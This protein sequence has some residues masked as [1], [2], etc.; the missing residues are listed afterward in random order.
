MKSEIAINYKRKV[1]SKYLPIGPDQITNK[2][3]ESE[4]YFVSR[5]YDGHLYLLFFDGKKAILKNHGGAELEDLELLTEFSKQIKSKDSLILAGELYVQ[6]DDKRTRSFDVTAAL[7]S[8]K[9]SLRFAVFDIVEV[10]GNKPEYG[11]KQLYDELNKLLTKDLEE[12]HIVDGKWFE[13][14]KEIEVYF[15]KLVTQFNA[16]GI[17]VKAFDGPIYKIKPYITI[18]AVIIGFSEGEDSRKGMIREFLIGL[19]TGENEYVVLTQLGN[20][21][22]DKD[23]E[24]WYKELSKEIVESDFIE[25]SKANL[26]FNMIKPTRVIELSCTDLISQNT[27]GQ[28]KKMSLSYSKSN[29]YKAIGKS[30]VV[31]IFSPVFVKNRED[32]KANLED[33]GIDQVTR[34]IEIDPNRSSTLIDDSAQSEIIR[35]DVYV[36]ES[37]GSKMVRK[38]VAWKTNKEH[39]FDYP[40][41]VLFITDF[42]PSRSE[43]LK[44]KIRVSNS[45]GTII[46]YFN[47]EVE[48][49]IKKGWNKV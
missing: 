37:K 17:V 36:K 38:F 2:I 23:R 6:S 13:S 41:Y 31:S 9:K 1:A 34:L 20:G 7:K 26:A 47:K 43:K 10:N 32:K 46:S 35:R 21:L 27:K 3:L 48:K 33:A 40:A 45:E 25:V 18:D 22:S 49:N 15:N 12:V 39:T 44:T 5:K 28:I 29:G 30:P 11:L 14:R 19:V 24:L 42:S 8:N 16:E 4:S